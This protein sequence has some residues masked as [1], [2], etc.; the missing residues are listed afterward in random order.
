MTTPLSP[1][2]PRD[3]ALT[4]R[5]ARLGA[6]PVD[7]SSLDR[8]L[9]AA[10]PPARTPAKWRWWARFSAVAASLLIIAS[11]ALVMSQE[12]KAQAAPALMAQMHMDI[13][14]GKTPTVKAQSIEEA[15]RLVAAMA[16]G[17]PAIPEPPSHTMACCVQKIGHAKVVCVLLDD[18]G[19][20]VTMAV[21]DAGQV[22]SPDSPTVE[23]HGMVFH[24]QQVGAL[25]MVMTHRENR[26]ICLMGQT[27]R[28]KL[29]ELAEAL[30]F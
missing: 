4:R 28:D 12:R 17:G 18:G 26:W 7:T 2:D 8:A 25:Q 29:I 9:R 3:A 1:D 11:V 22:T 24:V 5:L 23:R 15:N 10:I 14:S 21:A 27:S 30:H 6:T 13:V 19:T 16:G 20:P